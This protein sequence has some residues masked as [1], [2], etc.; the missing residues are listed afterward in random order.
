MIISANAEMFQRITDF[1]Q[2]YLLLVLMPQIVWVF[3]NGSG[4]YAVC[5]S[6]GQDGNVRSFIQHFTKRNSNSCSSEMVHSEDKRKSSRLDSLDDVSPC[7]SPQVDYKESSNGF[8]AVNPFSFNEDFDHDS[9]LK[10]TQCTDKILDV[11]SLCTCGLE[12][13]SNEIYND[14]DPHGGW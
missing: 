11:S 9:E 4:F 1:F 3:S 7:T 13:S 10:R 8:S 5:E 2:L 6:C 14:S 12:V